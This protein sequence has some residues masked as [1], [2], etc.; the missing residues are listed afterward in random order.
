MQACFTSAPSDPVSLVCAVGVQRQCHQM[1]AN[2]A[3]QAITLVRA[4]L[5]LKPEAVMPSQS[6]R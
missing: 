3:V 6:A 4:T 2:T 1:P 5:E